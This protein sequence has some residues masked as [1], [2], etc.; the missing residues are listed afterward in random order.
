MKRNS[1]LV[2]YKGGCHCKKIRFEVIGE[3]N[4]KVFKCNCSVCSM[5]QNH[6]FIVKDRQ[7]DFK[8]LSGEEYLSTYTFNTKIAQ[9]KFC[10][11]CGVQ[12]FYYPRSNPHG[13]AITIYCLDDYETVSYTIIDF[14]GRNWE[15]EMISNK[16]IKK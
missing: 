15:Q 5:K 10:K 13:V 12:S 3:K 4:L 1:D 9:H 8:I 6:H 7:Q 14:D 11:E 16:E 2:L